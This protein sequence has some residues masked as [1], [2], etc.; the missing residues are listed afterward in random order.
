MKEI[1]KKGLVPAMP[2]GIKRAFKKLLFRVGGLGGER[3]QH[4]TSA[5]AR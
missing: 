3:Q 2:E 1:I 5:H 4:R